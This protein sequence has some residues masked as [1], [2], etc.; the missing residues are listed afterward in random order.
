VPDSQYLAIPQKQNRVASDLN[1]AAAAKAATTVT[2]MFLETGC[3][4]KLIN[5]S[6]S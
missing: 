4:S 3:A 1:G 5:Q 6:G 2:W